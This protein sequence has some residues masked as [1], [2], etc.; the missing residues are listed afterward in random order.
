MRSWVIADT[1]RHSSATSQK[2]D[3]Q[4]TRNSADLSLRTLVSHVSHSLSR[5]YLEL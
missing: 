1:T 2:N 5:P 4:K 3:A